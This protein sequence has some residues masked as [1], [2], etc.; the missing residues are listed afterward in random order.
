LGLLGFDTFVIAAIITV[1]RS[2][3]VDA[4]RRI[5]VP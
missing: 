2:A 1:P 3:L 4:D 5:R